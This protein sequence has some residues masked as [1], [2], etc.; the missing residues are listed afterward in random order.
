MITLEGVPTDEES[1]Y[2]IKLIVSFD[3][4]NNT[5]TWLSSDSYGKNDNILEGKARTNPKPVY[6]STLTNDTSTFLDS[7]VC[8]KRATHRQGQTTHVRER[9]AGL[10]DF[11]Q[12]DNKPCFGGVCFFGM[13]VHTKKK[14]PCSPPTFS[15]PPALRGATSLCVNREK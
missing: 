1:Q 10:A 14:S 2:Y 6:K 8:G 4:K 12:P 7:Q 3:C 9:I 15:M 5:A 11:H 13:P